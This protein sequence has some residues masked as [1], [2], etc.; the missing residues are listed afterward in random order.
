MNRPIAISLS[1]NLEK[2]DVL[3]TLKLLFS[4]ITWFNFRKTERL[5]REF[6]RHF[7][8]EYGAV[9]VNSGRSALYLILKAL[10][11]GGGSEVALQALT[12]VA[13]PNSILWLNGRPKYVDIDNSFNLSPKDLSEKLSEKTKAIIVQHTFGIPADIGEIIKIAKRRKIMV[14]EDCALA[15]GATFNKKLLGTFGDISFF[16]FGRDK[17]IS[18]VFGGMILCKNKKMY[19]KLLDVRDELDYPGPR[20]LVQ[21]LLHP[22]LFSIILPLYQ[23]GIGKL[24]IGKVMIFLLQTFSVLSKP[25]Y[26]DEEYG[27][28]PKYF[29]AKMPGA[30]A[31]LALSQLK[32]L[33]IF[34]NHR[35]NIAKIYFRLLRKTNF[36]VPQNK[37]GTIW[38]RF[39][40][41]TDKAADIIKCAKK[42]GVLLGDWYK[43]VVV[44]VEDLSFVEYERG[45]CP[46][47]QK[48]A[49]KIVNLPTYPT[50]SEDE[51]KEVV[52]L[53][54]SCQ[55]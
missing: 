11:V 29:P 8:K 4:P 2:D 22:I 31:E 33:D 7:G 30:L 47:A 10:G 48:I 20:W 46:N 15:L 17:V 27:K 36:K 28:R 37:K 34:N 42:K 40:L 21:Q 24:T 52:R 12:C 18:S 54:K 51:A 41:V 53:I 49:G 39:P 45:S 35:K 32:K 14:I 43:D 13:V 5:E 50:L 26:K 55:N 23:I 9:A 16:S 6:A 25:V 1:P 38:I 19:E 3:L 44:P